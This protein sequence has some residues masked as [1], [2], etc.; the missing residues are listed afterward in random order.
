MKKILHAVLVSLLTDAI[1]GAVKALGTILVAAMLLHLFP[2]YT[3]QMG[4]LMPLHYIA[5]R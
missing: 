3:D 2:G 4:G 5:Q 1:K